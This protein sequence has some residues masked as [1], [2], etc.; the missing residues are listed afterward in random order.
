MNFFRIHKINYR[1]RLLRCI[2]GLLL[3]HLHHHLAPHVGGDSCNA[4]NMQILLQGKKENLTRALIFIELNAL[5]LSLSLSLF[6]LDLLF[7]LMCVIFSL[8]RS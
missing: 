4:Q 1:I 5:S 3:Q 7:I 6:L 2:S 8:S